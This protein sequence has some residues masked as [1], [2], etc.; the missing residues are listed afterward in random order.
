M[1]DSDSARK[2]G[3]ATKL[4]IDELADGWSVPQR[5]PTDEGEQVAPVPERA[6]RESKPPLSPPGSPE[7]AKRE[8][9]PPLP[10]PG[11]PERAKRESK[12][13]PPAQG[14]AALPPPVSSASR[15]PARPMPAAAPASPTPPDSASTPVSLGDAKSSSAPPITQQVFRL[16]AARNAENVDFRAPATLRRKRGL[17][18]DAVY[19]KSVLFGVAADRRK[20]QARHRVVAE[21][22][23]RRQSALADVAREA[24]A[25][26]ACA[27][28][29]RDRFVEVEEERS[30]LAGIV[31]ATDAELASAEADG[32]AELAACEAQVG[33][34]ETRV[35]ALGK[36][37]APIDR[38]L[39]K[40][41]RR[42]ADLQGKITTLESQITERERAL[43]S[44]TGGPELEADAAA[45]R[46]DL[47]D[48]KSEQPAIAAELARLEPE[49]TRVSSAIDAATRELD[50][51]RAAARAST[52]RTAEVIAALQARRT[53]E[54]RRLAESEAARDS[55]L[56]TIGEAV[57]VSR[58]A[59]LDERFAVVDELDGELETQGRAVLELEER[60]SAIDRAKLARGVALWIAVVA[61][62]VVATALALGAF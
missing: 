50:E 30:R 23:Q 39:G 55:L 24:L 60:L 41:R 4:R 13:P 3:D 49:R 19:V 38:D 51:A 29:E 7:R 35:K 27:P 6:K 2:V 17:Y 43:V 42:A 22:R 21:L 40:W 58:P 47:D 10:P 56:I 31:A 62:V 32:S 53:V 25:L 26:D 33:D 11:S 45:L 12:P 15:Q 20:L 9:K 1:S 18:G 48:L 52:E 14:K 5:D 36:E 8:S 37:L 28:A 44:A 46:A 59:G 34:I 54:A 16:E 61:L 57:A